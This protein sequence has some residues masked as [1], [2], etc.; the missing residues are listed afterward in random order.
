[1]KSSRRTGPVI[2]DARE[3]VKDVEA[4]FQDKREKYEEFVKLLQD[5]GAKRISRR[6]VKKGVTELLKEH[7]DLISRFNIFLP[8]GDEIHLPLD[9]DLQQ[10]DRSALE[11]EAMV[12]LAAVKV[13]FEDKMEKFNEFLK[14][15]ADYGAKRIDGRVVKEGITE[16]FKDHKDLLLGVNT[17]LPAGHKISLPLDD[18]LRQRD[19][20]VEDEAMAFLTAVKVTFEDK[21]EKLDEFLKLLA[22]YRAKRI[23]V[24]VV[25]EGMMELFEDHQ[26]L[27]LGFNTFLPE[28]HK[29]HFHWMMMNNNK[30]DYNHACGNS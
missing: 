12:F 5:F 14:L 3:F 28:G 23:D 13:T 20:S 24:R 2:G 11:D 26:D 22:D 9:D 7:Q 6:V 21:R 16:L 19:R 30:F 18:D 29:S 10:G 4:V 15:L 17:W 25:K 8:P 1:M 27:L